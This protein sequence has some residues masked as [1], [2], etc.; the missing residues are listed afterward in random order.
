MKVYLL[1]FDGEVHHDVRWVEDGDVED[2]DGTWD[3]GEGGDII[4]EG[5]EV[6]EEGIGGSEAVSKRNALVGDND[7]TGVLSVETG[8]SQTIGETQDER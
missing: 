8:V 1:V 5:V 4:E 3:A 6:V 2:F 7:S